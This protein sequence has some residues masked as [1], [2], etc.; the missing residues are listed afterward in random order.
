M[1]VW[2]TSFVILF[3]FA[4]LLDWLRHLELPLPAMVV[5][6]LVLAIA[7]NYDK[8]GTFPLWPLDSP[9]IQQQA[10]PSDQAQTG[11]ELP[12]FNN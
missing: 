8:R 4:Q 12:P 2:M 5:G 6:G 3:V 7:S 10:P 11:P 1:R 9:Q